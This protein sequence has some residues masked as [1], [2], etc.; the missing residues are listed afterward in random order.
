M[1]IT[2][3]NI[4]FKKNLILILAHVYENTPSCTRFDFEVIEKLT[5]HTPKDNEEDVLV[6]L[7]TIDYLVR[8]DYLRFDS[9]YVRNTSMGQKVI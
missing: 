3:K 1:Q 8:E 4:A 5:G 6:F 2:H 7:E 9:C